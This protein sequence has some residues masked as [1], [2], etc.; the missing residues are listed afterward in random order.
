ME[1]NEKEKTVIIRDVKENA[2]RFHYDGWHVL[3]EGKTVEIFVTTSDNQLEKIVLPWEKIDR[4][5]K[6]GL[7]QQE[8][9]AKEVMKGK[10]VHCRHLKSWHRL[11]PACCQI[12]KDAGPQYI[13]C[14]TCKYIDGYIEE[15]DTDKEYEKVVIVSPKMTD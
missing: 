11:F 4:I 12:G 9:V 6:C 3:D 7:E 8:D 1:Q 15:Y 5:R 10:R 2:P 14:I 13:N